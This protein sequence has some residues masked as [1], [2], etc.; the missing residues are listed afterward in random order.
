MN[1][2]FKTNI[3]LR[4]AF[5]TIYLLLLFNALKLS[6]FLF[7][8][9][10]YDISQISTE[11]IGNSIALVILALVYSRYIFVVYQIDKDFFIVRLISGTKKYRY[12]DIEYLDEN[13]PLANTL[14]AIKINL[15]N[16]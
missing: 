12:R 10:E 11:L 6:F 5:G 16:R 8:G 4:L 13:F 7:I 3:I 2:S 15:K 1:K 9:G 14:N